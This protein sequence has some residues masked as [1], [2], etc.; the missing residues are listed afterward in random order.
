[1]NLK[2]KL[3]IGAVAAALLAANGAYAAMTN[4]A[5]GSSSLVL[6]VLDDTAATNKITGM[7]DLGIDYATFLPS[8]LYTNTLGQTITWNLAGN[9]VGSTVGSPP[10]STGSWSTAWSA[11][12]AAGIA[13]DQ[14]FVAAADN[15]GLAGARGI[16][17]TVS[18]GQ[19]SNVGTASPS[20]IGN[21][22][23][24]L[25]RGLNYHNTL[26]TH[27]SA[28]DGGSTTADTAA[29]GYID[30][31]FTSG[32]NWGNQM[33][34]KAVGNYGDSLSFYKLVN[35]ATLT[36]NQYA[37]AFSLT[38]AGVLTYTTAPGW[39]WWRASLVAA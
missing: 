10:A 24:A 12:T 17:S 5:S 27:T 14:W 35:T 36:S 29:D 38:S 7:F 3:R 25:D 13:G 33:P 21:A 19:E 26:T 20:N 28:V 31:F 8:S 34:F 4:A 32:L 15:T 6:V 1:M 30:N 11:I 23:T 18:L 16:I 22:A 2:T 37:G 39:Y 9:T